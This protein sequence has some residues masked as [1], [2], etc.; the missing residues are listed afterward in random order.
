MSASS[1]NPE[2]PG[3][4]PGSDQPEPDQPP[5]PRQK[6]A[7]SRERFLLRLVALILISEIGLYTVGTA[8]CFY[9]T[10]RGGGPAAAG[11]VCSRLD[12]SIHSAFSVALNTV[13]ALLGGKGLVDLNSNQRP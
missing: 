6:Q 4:R 1:R 7:F 2:P 13:L 5:G 12:N 10:S 3:Q 9:L 8:G 11:G